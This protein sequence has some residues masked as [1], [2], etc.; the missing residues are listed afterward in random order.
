[1]KNNE[2]VMDCMKEFTSK[3]KKKI[4]EEVKAT[5]AKYGLPKFDKSKKKKS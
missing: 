2:K 1:M 3:E 4:A 5:S